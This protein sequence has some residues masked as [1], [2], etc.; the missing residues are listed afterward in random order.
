MAEAQIQP[1]PKEMCIIISKCTQDNYINQYYFFFYC[2]YTL[3]NWA[4]SRGSTRRYILI[5]LVVLTVI[6][7]Q[8]I[9]YAKLQVAKDW[10][11]FFTLI[12]NCYTLNNTFSRKWV[13]SPLFSLWI[14]NFYTLSGNSNIITHNYTC[15]FTFNLLKKHIFKNVSYIAWFAVLMYICHLANSHGQYSSKIN[16]F[17][18]TS[19]NI[20]F[21]QPFR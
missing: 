21:Y 14:L 6:F 2:R 18:V 17:K 5:L 12:H 1:T 13:G 20:W 11:F 8:K 7:Y 15:S 4:Q 10:S 9:L 16:K 3:F 19:Y